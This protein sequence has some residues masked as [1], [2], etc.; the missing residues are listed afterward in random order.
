[1][2]QMGKTK[3]PEYLAEIQTK[4]VLRK[5]QEINNQS[6][7]DEIAAT[8][9]SA[10]HGSEEVVLEK[11]ERHAQV[12]KNLSSTETEIA[13]GSATPENEEGTDEKNFAGSL[14][15]SQTISNAEAD[16]PLSEGHAES[17]G[18]STDN[19]EPELNIP[20]KT[21]E[22]K[23][24]PEPADKKEAE[25]IMETSVFDKQ[26]TVSFN[27]ANMDYEIGSQ[28][29]RRSDRIRKYPSFLDVTH[30]TSPRYKS[31]KYD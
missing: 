3:S 10:E 2:S 22:E 28:E 26:P 21:G 7:A 12:R 1:M 4:E 11:A 16:P 6:I 17:D 31:L 19:A 9:T 14:G 13:I 30:T 29:L 23:Q 15:V 25:N 24:T 18:E 27:I 20:T 5:A 8:L